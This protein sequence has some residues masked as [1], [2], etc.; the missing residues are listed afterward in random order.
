MSAWFFLLAYLGGNSHKTEEIRFFTH[1]S[2]FPGDFA[3][4]SSGSFVLLL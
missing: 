2:D 3:S 1:K 4:L